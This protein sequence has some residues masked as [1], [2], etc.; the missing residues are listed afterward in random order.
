[1]DL[2]FPRRDNSQQMEAYMKDSQVKNEL[3]GRNSMYKGPEAKENT[4]YWKKRQQAVWCGH[5]MEY[6]RRLGASGPG[7]PSESREPC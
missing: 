3:C 4:A 6:D 2:T 5:I 7:G 1:M